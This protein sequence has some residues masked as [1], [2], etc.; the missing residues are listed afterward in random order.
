[1]YKLFSCHKPYVIYEVSDLHDLAYNRRT[2]FRARALKAF[3]YVAEAIASLFVNALIITAPGFFDQYYCRFYRRSKVT[4]I[5]N[6]PKLDALTRYRPKTHG[7]F[8]VGFIG[9]V[10]YY[11]Q[12]CAL[13]DA[14][15][16]VSANVLIAGYGPALEKLMAYAQ[17]KSN[18][19]FR[20]SYDYS[21]DIAEL[22]S[23]VNAVYAAYDTS[24]LNTT[25]ALPNRL[26]EAAACGLPIIASLGTSLGSL[27]E[28]F[29]LGVQVPD[30]DSGALAEALIYLMNV[31]R[32]IFED[33]GARFLK[34]IPLQEANAQLLKLYEEGIASRR[35]RRRSTRRRTNY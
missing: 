9:N 26:Y 25:V 7:P 10:R 16:T 3:L 27:V 12:I 13:I 29:G 24:S 15:D 31:D 11:R 6:T 17:S 8:T 18:V 21:R 19:T 22:Y 28:S 34:S 2:D 1:M 5:H 35:W 23:E 4:L 14:S 33:A 20:G 32:I 30:S